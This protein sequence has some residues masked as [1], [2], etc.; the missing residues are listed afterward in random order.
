MAKA[1]KTPKTSK[2]VKAGKVAVRTGKGY[3]RLVVS[4]STRY[5]SKGAGPKK[6]KR[7][8]T[9]GTTTG[10]GVVGAVAGAAVGGA[11]GS[12]TGGVA[13]KAAGQAV[14][15]VAGAQVGLAAGRKI[16]RKA[17]WQK[18]T[19]Q[20]MTVRAVKKVQAKRKK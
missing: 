2:R 3:G 8:K 14:G 15:R 4:G 10:I 20:R 19:K 11:V 12:R 9:Y 18:R 13:G 7:L 1:R 16:A 5:T 6:L 17:G